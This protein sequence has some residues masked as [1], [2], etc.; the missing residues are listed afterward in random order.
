MSQKRERKRL[1]KRRAQAAAYEKKRMR[2]EYLSEEGSDKQVVELERQ[3][4][5]I[6]YSMASISDGGRAWLDIQ[7][8]RE[9]TAE[10]RMNSEIMQ[11]RMLYACA[12]QLRGG[13]SVGKILSAAG[14]YV[15]IMAMSP[16]LRATANKMKADVFG[17][18]VDHMAE[19]PDKKFLG[20]D[21]VMN[22]LAKKRDAYLAAANDGRMP[23]TPETAAV[24]DIRLSREAYEK[25]RQTD[26]LKTP[27][28]IAAHQANVMHRYK[29]ARAVLHEMMGADGVTMADMAQS[30]RTIVTKFAQR[31]PKYAK[32]FSEM[33]YGTWVKDDPMRV[34]RN[35]YDENNMPHAK[36]FDVWRGGYTDSE[37]GE[38]V[39]PTA[40]FTVREPMTDDDYVRHVMEV[41]DEHDNAYNMADS[42]EF[43]TAQRDIGNVCRR[44]YGDAS[45]TCATNDPDMRNAFDSAVDG[46][47]RYRDMAV[48]DWNGTTS[49]D[50]VTRAKAVGEREFRNMVRACDGATIKRTSMYLYTNDSMDSRYAADISSLAK[51]FASRTAGADVKSDAYQKWAQR[52]SNDYIADVMAID[53][54]LS[55]DLSDDARDKALGEYMKGLSPEKQQYYFDMRDASVGAMIVY[56]QATS[57]MMSAGVSRDEAV[58]MLSYAEDQGAECWYGDIPAC[59]PAVERSRQWAADRVGR[60]G[61]D[62]QS[63]VDTS[64]ADRHQTTPPDF[65][66]SGSTGPAGKSDGSQA[67]AAARAADRARKAEARFGDLTRGGGY[68]GPQYGG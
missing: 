56:G 43:S 38:E 51:E 45:A 41:I 1:E 16:Q 33:G 55:K 58:D 27:E 17:K 11:R 19:N 60:F 5:D 6:S 52:I 23:F 24:A 57:D 54:N 4:D 36:D 44:V 22:H 39:N 25:M 32:M 47:S 35:V 59:R 3:L 10:Q 65:S 46:L 18:A 31:D 67:D 34:T 42:L 2:S 53:A 12:N 63:E 48:E 66:H 8:K 68:D 29:D 64:Y 40:T 21:A 14:M 26:G 9:M 13:L 30:Q 7:D 20:R 49:G 62:I 50:D 15:G 28:E 37:T 61:D